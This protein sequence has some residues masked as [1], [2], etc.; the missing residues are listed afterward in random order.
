MGDQWL[1]LLKT[2]PRPETKNFVKEGVRK[3]LNT[4]KNKLRAKAPAKF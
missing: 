3:K 1:W 4:Y 2:E